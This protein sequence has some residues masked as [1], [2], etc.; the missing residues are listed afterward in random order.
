[1]AATPLNDG[2]VGSRIENYA[3]FWQKDIQKEGQVDSDIRV[4]NYTDV[5]NGTA[6]PEHFIFRSAASLFPLPVRLLRRRHGTLRVRLG[7]VV[8]L[9]AL[10]QG[11]IVRRV[12]GPSRALPRLSDV[13]SSG[14][15]RS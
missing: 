7:Q 1:M 13:P 10:L 14:D 15:A 12:P 5:V 11:R 6:R 3:G 4:E 8:P 2:R 9:L